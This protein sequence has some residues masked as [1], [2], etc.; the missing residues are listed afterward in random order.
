MEG[1]LVVFEVLSW[2]ISIG[3]IIA[4]LLTPVEF[5]GALTINRKEVI[6]HYWRDN[7]LIFDICGALPFNWMFGAAFEDSMIITHLIRLL[8]IFVVGKLFI[9]FEKLEL[10][11]RKYNFT[12]QVIK[13]LL[14]LYF[15]W[16]WTACAW[17]F[18]NVYYEKETELSW[19][20][21]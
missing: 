13:P 19:I 9:Y 21:E 1:G 20:R 8:R 15:L 11:F 14:F 6:K 12:I 2:L 17:F 10:T 5:D 18:L 16:E 4:T 3:V 7:G